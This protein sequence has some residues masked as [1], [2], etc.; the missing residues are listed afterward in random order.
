[1]LRGSRTGVSTLVQSHTTNLLVRIK[2]S[3][4]C[5]DHKVRVR[6]LYDINIIYFPFSTFLLLIVSVL[7][8]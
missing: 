8:S 7:T 5:D 4:I 2:T 3:K 1:M 6:M